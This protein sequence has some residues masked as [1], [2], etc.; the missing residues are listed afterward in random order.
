MSGER[1]MID[2]NMRRQCG[3]GVFSEKCCASH[4]TAASLCSNSASE[5]CGNLPVALRGRLSTLYKGRG[6]NAGSIFW[7]NAV[8]I[9]L[10]SSVGATTKALSRVTSPDVYSGGMKNAPSVTPGIAFKWWFKYANELRLPAML[11]RS[12][13]RPCNKNFPSPVNS[14]ASF[15][16]IGVST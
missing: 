16:G 13:M 1:R 12:V 3:H 2:R 5:A 4:D 10:T 11:I 15:I 6:K 9:S 8:T 14:M 7:R